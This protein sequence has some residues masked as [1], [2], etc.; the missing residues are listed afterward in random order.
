MFDP[1][2]IGVGVLVWLAFKK[3]SGTQFGAVTPERAEL[4]ENAMAYCADPEKLKTLA[5]A[6]EK[7]GL[8]AQAAVLKKRAEWRARSA[9]VRAEHARIFDS[10]MKSDKVD[11]ILTIAACFEDLTA[12]KKAAELRKRAQVVN[13]EK[14]KPEPV[15]VETVVETKAEAAE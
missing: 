8:K 5:R 3:Q 15:A 2:T 10:A 9:E 6:F 12:T 11:V 1:L 7:E 13:E 14:L 4:Y